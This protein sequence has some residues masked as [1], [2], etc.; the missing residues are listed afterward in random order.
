LGFAATLNKAILTAILATALY[1]LLASDVKSGTPAQGGH[2]R[3][4]DDARPLFEGS[5]QKDTDR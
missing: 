5:V 4:V 3:P 2:L 1:W